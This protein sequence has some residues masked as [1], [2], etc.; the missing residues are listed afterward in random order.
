MVPHK[1]PLW[2]T[3][4]APPQAQDGQRISSTEPPSRPSFFTGLHRVPP[5][6]PAKCQLP[7]ILTAWR[8]SGARVVVTAG[9]KGGCQI[10]AAAPTVALAAPCRPAAAPSQAQQARPGQ[11]DPGHSVHRSRGCRFRPDYYIH[12][13]VAAW[14]HTAAGYGRRNGLAE[15]RRCSL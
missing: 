4:P 14:K 2:K 8:P 13:V 12:M 1:T 5:N 10:L 11:D 3:L 15:W 7:A 6:S 9:R